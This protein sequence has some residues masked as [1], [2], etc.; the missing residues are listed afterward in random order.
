M[1]NL[2][3]DSELPDI[4][5]TMTNTPESK[6]ASG[7]VIPVT[8]ANSTPRGAKVSEFKFAPLPFNDEEPNGIVGTS[9]TVANVTPANVPFGETPQQSNHNEN[10]SDTV[11]VSSIGTCNLVHR[12][13]FF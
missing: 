13:T 2:C 10:S 3:A 6:Y 12:N 7:S 4:V 11:V 8:P 9:E 1:S 5:T